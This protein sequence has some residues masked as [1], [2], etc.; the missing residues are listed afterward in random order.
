VSGVRQAGAATPP[1][2]TPTRSPGSADSPS[3]WRTFG[4][5]R[6]GNG[7]DKKKD[8]RFGS[9]L[10]LGSSPPPKVVPPW[11]DRKQQEGDRDASRTA[12][13][14]E[15][16]AGGDSAAATPT[17][18]PTVRVRRN[19]SLDRWD[20]APEGASGGRVG[21]QFSVSGIGNKGRIY[22]KW[23]SSLEFI[24][25]GSCADALGPRYVPP[26]RATR[27]QTLSFPP[28]P[29]TTRRRWRCPRPRPG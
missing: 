5:L 13:G 2:G 8:S 16:N 7:K 4:S 9:R 17:T 3:R 20:V 22:L 10:R 19:T 24:L 25:F 18:T 12:A 11:A 15:G 21:R 26:T 14:I 27:N 6:E 23:V 28:S 29:R 1:S